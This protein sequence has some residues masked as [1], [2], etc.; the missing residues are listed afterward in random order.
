MGILVPCKSPFDF[1]PGEKQM[2]TDG[3]KGSLLSEVAISRVMMEQ[4]E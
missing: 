1:F 3:T 2:L 4:L